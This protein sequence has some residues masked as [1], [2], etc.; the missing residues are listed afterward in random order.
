[1]RFLLAPDKFRGSLSAAAACAAMEAGIRLVMP[2]AQVI[3]LPMADGG[4]GTAELLT[5]TTQGSWHTTQVNNPL[6]KPIEAGFGLSADGKIAFID[7]AAA[8]GLALL[9]LQ[10]RN[11]SLTTTYGLGQ[12]IQ[13]AVRLGAST[14]VLGLGGSG[15]TDGGVG[16]AAA[17]GWQFLYKSGEP[18]IPTGGTLT[19]IDRIQPPTMPVS[20]SFR[21]ACDVQ[22]PLYGPTGAAYMF[23][24]QKGATPEQVELLDQGLRHLDQLVATQLC[25][26]NAYVPGAG[27]AGGLGYGLITFLAAKLEPGVDVVLDAVNF[28]QQLT[29]TDLVLTGEGKLDQQTAQGK[30]IAGIC[31]RAGRANVP[32]VAL[33]GTLDLAP[34]DIENIGL[35]AAF[36]VLNSPQL[37]EEAVL[38]AA[39]DLQ[40][41]TFNVMR[42]LINHASLR[43]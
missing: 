25:L 12:L 20:V 11:P 4:E 30:L 16:L 7:S 17:L 35:L 14:V 13:Q 1:M 27:A 28:D 9:T 2:N 3:A 31:R 32:V 23:A 5:H 10:E 21:V 29:N 42:L 36:S 6:S 34:D 43:L 8:A 38:T 33:C 18:F 22:N 24:P 19:E 26:S 15:T 37:L 39:D 40:Q 41:T